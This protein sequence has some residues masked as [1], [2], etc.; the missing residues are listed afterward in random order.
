[1]SAP[2]E[3]DAEIQAARLLELARV[4][5]GD[6]LELPA[7]VAYL[8]QL[9][10]EQMLEVAMLRLDVAELKAEIERLKGGRS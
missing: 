10:A 3:P 1:M 4:Y 5:V 6:T 9:L 7:E 2:I 8:R